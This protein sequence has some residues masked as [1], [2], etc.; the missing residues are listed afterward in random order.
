MKVLIKEII[1]VNSNGV[2]FELTGKAALNG[3]LKADKWTVSWDKIGK[4][5][6][7]EQYSDALDVSELRAERGIDEFDEMFPGTM[8]ALNNLTTKQ[9][10]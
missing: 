5:L 2:S 1:N 7:K 8:E 4:S 6:F 9:G 3:S 10:E